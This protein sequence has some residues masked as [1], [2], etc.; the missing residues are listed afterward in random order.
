MATH[1]YIINQRSHRNNIA[2]PQFRRNKT[3]TN[4]SMYRRV[5]DRLASNTLASGRESTE[6]Y[7]AERN[8][9]V[10]VESS[11]KSSGRLKG[12]RTQEIRS[13]N[14]IDEKNVRNTIQQMIRKVIVFINK[15]S[16]IDSSN[17]YKEQFSILKK[18]TNNIKEEIKVTEE[19]LDARIK[20]LEELFKQAIFHKNEGKDKD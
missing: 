2:Y 4:G 17:E 1:G 13:G 6:G 12:V 15:R 5:S 10:N 11:S 19:R 16:P 7:V 20:P 8:E 18:V 14:G 9:R 3:A